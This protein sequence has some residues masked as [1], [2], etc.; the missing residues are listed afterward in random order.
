MVLCNLHQIPSQNLSMAFAGQTSI[1]LAFSVQ[2]C[3]LKNWMRL[4][5]LW[6]PWQMFHLLQITWLILG[7]FIGHW[8][9]ETCSEARASLGISCPPAPLENQWDTEPRLSPGRSVLQQ[10]WE[11]QMCWKSFPGSCSLGWKEAGGGEALQLGGLEGR[12]EGRSDSEALAEELQPRWSAGSR[13]G[14]RLRRADGRAG[15]RGQGEGRKLFPERRW[16]R[17]SVTG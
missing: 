2:S 5:F 16:Q 7:L 17:Q 14:A 6:S 3:L 11:L 13:A 4:K 1:T 10:L 8:C 9:G 15:C 12:K